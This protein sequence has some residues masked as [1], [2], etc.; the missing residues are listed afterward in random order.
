VTIA[1]GKDDVR[2]FGQLLMRAQRDNGKMLVRDV[3]QQ[4][5]LNRNKTR[6]VQRERGLESRITFGSG[7]RGR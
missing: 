4:L 6:A 5:D 7:G 1:Y 2:D 3:E